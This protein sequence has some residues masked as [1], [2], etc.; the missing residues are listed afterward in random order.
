MYIPVAFCRECF[1]TF[2]TIKWFVSSVN[3]IMLNQIC[4]L[5]KLLVAD[6]AP[7][8]AYLFVYFSHV[9]KQSFFLFECFATL[10]AFECPLRPM[11]SAMGLPIPFVIK[12][13]ATFTALII[14]NLFVYTP[15]VSD[16]I[17][18]SFE[19]FTAFSAF[20]YALLPNQATV[21]FPIMFFIP[22]LMTYICHG[23]SSTN[24]TVIHNDE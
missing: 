17:P 19:R 2:C 16:Q 22:L 11:Y 1:A 13:F 20:K 23:E 4:P 14:P 24:G 12:L 15:C 5:I 6:T 7:I 10:L 9:I 21:F 18:L 3:A 8:V